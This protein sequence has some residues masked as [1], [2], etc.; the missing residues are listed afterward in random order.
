MLSDNVEGLSAFGWLG[1]LVGM[2]T[3]AALVTTLV[4]FMLLERRH[5]RERFLTVVGQ[6]RLALTT[7]AL[8][9]AG[10]R[11]ARQ[12]LMQ[13]LVNG[14]Y[15]IIAGIGLSLLDVPHALVWAALGAV[16]RFVPYVGPVDRRGASRR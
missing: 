3:T 11:V 12:L 6:G 9:E 16:L 13:T 14:A 4:I 2:A 10:S 5:L 1:P 15:G 8:D 7:K